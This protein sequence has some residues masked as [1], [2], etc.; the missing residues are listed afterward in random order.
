MDFKQYSPEELKECS[1][2]E[3][4]H[5]VLG[6]KKQ[7]TTFNELVQEIAQVLGLSQEQ[8]NAKLAQFYTDLNIDGRFI[9]LGENRWGLRSWYPYEQIDEE[10]LPQPKPKKKR[11]VEEDGFDDYIEEDEDDFDDADGN[12]DDDEDDVEDLDKVLEDEDGDDDDLDDLEEDEDDDF[13]E[14]ELEYD[15]TEEEEEEEL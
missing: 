2:I 5:S 8:V 11:K 1:M 9:N 6:D 13:A 14:E 15:E 3:V 10:I 4:V 12:A 7:A